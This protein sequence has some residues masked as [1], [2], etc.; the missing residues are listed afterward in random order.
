LKKQLNHIKT[1]LETIVET[2]KIPYNLYRDNKYVNLNA[3][4]L[5]ASYPSIQAA[6]L[7]SSAMENAGCSNGAIS[8]GAAAV[9]LAAYIPIHMGLHYLSKRNHFRDEKGKLNKKDFWKDVGKVYLT[10]IPSIALFYIMATPLHYGLMKAGFEADDA[11][12]L[13]YWGTLL[14]TRTLHTYNYW[15]LQKL[16]IKKEV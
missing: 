14:A 10:Q 1:G 4:V 16:S 11:N 15:K 5:A 2:A 6:T 13:S 12:L 8:C 3:N 9:D 7:A